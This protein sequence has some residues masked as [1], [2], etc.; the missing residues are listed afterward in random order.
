MPVYKYVATDIKGKRSEGTI[1]VRSY[2]LALT[3]LKE[4][5]LYIISVDEK[6]TSLDDIIA[7]FRGVPFSE[8]VTFTRQFST[9][10]SAGLPLAKSLEILSSQS[11][12]R[13]FRQIIS[14][15]L[16]DVEGG[17]TLSG[18]MTKYPQVF[19]PTYQA[20]VR[21]G[22]SSGKLDAILDR[23]AD[24]LE[25]D[26][27]LSSKFKAAMIYPAI[28]FLA[29]VGVFIIMLV[30]V[31]PKLAA[32]YESLNVDLPLATKIMIWMSKFLTQYLAL[33]A[34]A[35]IAFVI[36]LRYYLRTPS[37]SNLKS[38]ILFYLPVFGKINQ[39][40]EVTQL[41]RT[42]SLLIGAAIPIVEA[43]NIVGG[44]LQNKRYKLA[45][46]E[47]AMAVEKGNPLSDYFK[48]NTVFP[49]ILGQ[50][51][52]VGEETGQLDTVLTKVANYFDSEVSNLVKGLSSALEP[53]ILIMLGGMVGGLILSIIVPIYKITSSL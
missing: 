7:N 37:G 36:G 42:L 48:R 11:A 40:K 52:A 32:M 14:N 20:L 13:T 2:D 19:S 26:R 10:I 30:V 50:M 41:A 29:M 53:M 33:I 21:A 44:V 28:V 23:L 27:E 38:I 45:M 49:P 3:L 35:A 16:K 12:N 22:E 43:L 15:V 51:A 1:D 25:A 9:M 5:G 8:I 47:A 39:K 24:N 31:V 18:A 4:Q 34:V 6:H 17:S 46:A